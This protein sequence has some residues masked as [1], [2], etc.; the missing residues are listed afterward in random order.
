MQATGSVSGLLLCTWPCSRGSGMPPTPSQCSLTSRSEG[1]PAPVPSC[2]LDGWQVQGKFAEGALRL[3][4]L[5]GGGPRLTPKGNVPVAALLS[6]ALPGGGSQASA[7]DTFPLSAPPSCFSAGYQCRVAA[8]AG[9]GGTHNPIHFLTRVFTVGFHCRLQVKFSW[10]EG[11]PGPWGPGPSKSGCSPAASGRGPSPH[12]SLRGI[13]GKTSPAG[14][15]GA[16][17][18]AID[19]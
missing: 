6:W 19:P 5:E 7:E 14:R 11:A 13:G 1:P 3:G 15:R 17:D 2:R 4:R 8:G 16:S 10:L 12:T 18:V 9:R